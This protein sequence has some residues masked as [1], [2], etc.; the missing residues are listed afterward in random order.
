MPG[1]RHPKQCIHRWILTLQEYFNRYHKD[2]YPTRNVQR[3]RLRGEAIL[4]LSKKFHLNCQESSHQPQM[5]FGEV[6][7]SIPIPKP[8]FDFS[9][10]CRFLFW[11]LHQQLHWFKPQYQKGGF[12]GSPMKLQPPDHRRM[13]GFLADLGLQ[14]VFFFWNKNSMKPTDFIHAEKRRQV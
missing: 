13:L 7:I 2:I 6:D 5:N 9:E 1:I 12:Q 4:A 14:V 10:F 8:F 3:L 11:K